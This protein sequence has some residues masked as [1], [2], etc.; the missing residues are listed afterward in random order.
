MAKLG[1]NPAISGVKRLPLPTQKR[2][3]M[4]LPAAAVLLGLAALTQQQLDPTLQDMHKNEQKGTSAFGGLNNEFL[5]LPLLGFREAAAGLLWVRCDEFFHSGDYDAILPLV[6]VIT[7]LDPKAD[8]VYITG[9]WHMSYNFTDSSERS[10][11]RYIAPS[12]ALL[13]EGVKN[14]MEI[15]DIKFELGWQNYDKIK[16]YVAAEAAFKMAL[17]T[18]PNPK[19]D[20]WP[21]G[22]PLKTWHILAHTYEKE[23]RIPEALAAWQAA[24]ARSGVELAKNPKDY[25]MMSMNHTEQHNFAETLQRFYD[26]YTP[27]RH[28]P[29]VNPT[30]YPAVWQPE[31]GHPVP[32]PW[33]VAFHPQI[34]V[35]RPKVLKISGEFNAADGARVDVRITDWTYK[36]RPINPAPTDTTIQTFDVEQS[37]TILMDSISVRKNHFEREMDMSKDPKMYS[38]TGD[39]YK[40]VLGYNPRVTSP[41]LEDRF[42]WSGEGMTDSNAQHIYI[43]HNP[44]LAGTTVFDKADGT[45]PIWNV[46]V[47]GDPKTS[48]YKAPKSKAGIPQL[49]DPTVIPAFDVKTTLGPTWANDAIP[50]KQHGQPPRMIRVTY[51]VS[52]DQIMGQRPITDADIVPN[53]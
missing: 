6:R 33:D 40:I 32:G 34:D 51:K 41:H 38:F 43:E 1:S 49:A 17:E 24:L 16:D 28:D 37:Q 5:L 31:T 50:W 15:P 13:W 9:A 7:F 8:N 11:R 3:K 18:K 39:Y 53:Q 12:E 36:E 22:A 35:T 19:G 23:G 47:I 20:D 52:R 25:S 4:L 2:F 26:R 46:N 42:G 14:N 21:Y 10:D 27:F 29:T 44:L 48:V 30:A 45:G